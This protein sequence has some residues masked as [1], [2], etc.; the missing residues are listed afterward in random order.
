MAYACNLLWKDIMPS[1]RHHMIWAL[2]R[3]SGF[4]FRMEKDVRN[5]TVIRNRPPASLKSRIKKETFEGHNIWRIQP[6]NFVSPPPAKTLY[7][8]HGGGHVYGVLSLHFKVLAQLADLAQAEIILPCYPLPP[9]YEAGGV[10]TFCRNHFAHIAAQKGLENITLSGDSAG[11]G[12]ALILSAYRRDAGLVN[13]E[14]LIL[15]SPWVNLAMDHA[16]SD[17]YNKCALSVSYTHLTL[18]TKA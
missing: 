15:W 9:D 18:P 10:N 6:D 4:R 17:A 14:R 7:H 13:P 2:L 5:G 8:L 1:L 16:E 3:L 12:L 11:A